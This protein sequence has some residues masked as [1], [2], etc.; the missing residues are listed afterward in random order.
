LLPTTAV[1]YAFLLTITDDVL[2]CQG[3]EMPRS[4]G[5]Y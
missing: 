3:V 1:K 2:N 5:G 4:S